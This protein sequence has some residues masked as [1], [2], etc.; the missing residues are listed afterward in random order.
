MFTFCLYAS[1]YYPNNHN[2]KF[3]V[4]LENDLL[5]P[6]DWTCALVGV[7]FPSALKSELIICCDAVQTSFIVDKKTASVEKNS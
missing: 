1:E 5:L 6:G 2:G 4:H 3:T 7:N